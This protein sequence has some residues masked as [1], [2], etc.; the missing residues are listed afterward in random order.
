MIGVAL[1]AGA[2]EMIE[3]IVN[4]PHAVRSNPWRLYAQFRANLSML[5]RFRTELLGCWR[6]APPQ[7]VIADFVVPVAG[8][9]ALRAGDSLVDECPVAVRDR[10]A[11]RAA[12]IPRRVEAVAGS[13]R[14]PA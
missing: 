3:A 8:S 6:E 9:A 13:G 10:D 14:A 1:L 12:G 7:L 2:D 11:R 5:D 4:P